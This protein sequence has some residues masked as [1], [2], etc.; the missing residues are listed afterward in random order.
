MRKAFTLI[1]L[2][3]V[4]AII[5]ILAAILF[6]VFAQAKTA[7]KRT[8]TLSNVKNVGTSIQLYMADY[9]DILPR[10]DDCLPSP[11]LNPTLAATVPY[12]PTKR[13]VGCTTGNFVYRTNH[14][15]WQKWVFPYVKNIEIFWN[16]LRERGAAYNTA[17]QITDQFGINTGLTGALNSLTATPTSG[18]VLRD[19]WFGGSGTGIVSPSEAFILMEIGGAGSPHITH[20][21]RD[22]FQYQQTTYPVAIREYWRYRL[23]QGT[24]ADCV[25]GTAGTQPDSRKTS[26]GQVILGFMDS[27]AKSMPAAMFLARTPS[28]ADSGTTI[29]FNAASLCDITRTGGNI[30]VSSAGMNTTINFPMWNFGG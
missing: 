20:A 7:A 27:S 3:V 1:E 16:P 6:P 4:I 28:L 22:P 30:G 14:F 29:S 2:L 21:T 17:G 10:Q 19:S 15:A 23:M 24:A 18:G 8:Q 25:A 26:N 5:A 11:V 13:G 9:D 12:P